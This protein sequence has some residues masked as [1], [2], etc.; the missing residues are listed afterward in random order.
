MNNVLES[1]NL[2]RGYSQ[3]ENA[4]THAFLAFLN[5][6]LHA[7]ARAFQTYWHSLGLW[8]RRVTPSDVEIGCLTHENGGTWDGQIRSRK[9]GWFVAVESKLK[10]AALS[11]NQLSRHKKCMRGLTGKFSHKKLLL[12]TP[13]DKD[14][15]VKEFLRGRCNHNV[16]FLSWR[17]VY[18]STIGLRG[19]VSGRGQE[20]VVNQYGAYLEAAN[21][22]RSGII[23]VLNKKHIGDEVARGFQSGEYNDFHIPSKKIGFDL[24]KFKVFCYDHEK[25][26]ISWYFTS[27]GM[28]LDRIRVNGVDFKHY[29]EVDS[30]VTLKTPI[31]TST[32]RSVLGRREMGGNYRAYQSFKKRN[33][34]APYYILNRKMVDALV[35]EASNYR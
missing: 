29:F 13:F 32:I 5:F 19:K 27:N 31:A 1:M 28:R 20:F 21:G 14:W 34:P 17:D 30:P 15:I 25:G 35:H 11:R 18:E 3:E 6:L 4:Q 22:D 8:P 7:N 26:G 33:C 9:R 23:Q 12:L 24:P 10:K 2:F 16:T